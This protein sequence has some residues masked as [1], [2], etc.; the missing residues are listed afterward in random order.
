MPEIHLGPYTSVAT[1]M[2][3]EL[4]ALA[5]STGKAI[6]AA[7]DN[8]V[9]LN[10]WADLELAVDFVTA[11]TASTVIEL[12]LLPSIDATLYPDGDASILPQAALYVGGFVV[13]NTTAAQRMTIRSIVLPPGKYKWVVQ[14]TTNQA[15]PAT[16]SVLRQSDYAMQSV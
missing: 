6:S 10:I 12:Y 15:F 14:N 4:N 8:S 1:V 3:T 9:L 7:Q 13:R 5:A 2:S 16:G 11:P